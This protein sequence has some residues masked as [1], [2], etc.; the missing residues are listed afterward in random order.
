M[1]TLRRRT[2]CRPARLSAV[3]AALTCALLGSVVWGASTV[4]TNAPER[5]AEINVRDFGAVG[6]GVHDDTAA[7][8]KA[9]AW[10]MANRQELKHGVRRYRNV[11]RDCPTAPIRFPR[12]VYRITRPI[13]V[14]GDAILL[15]EEGARIVNAS[16]DKETFYFRRARY[17]RVTHLDFEGGLTQVRLWTGNRECSYLHVADCTFRNATGTSVECISRRDPPKTGKPTEMA[18]GETR[19]G[20]WHNSTLIIVERSRFLGNNMALRMFSDGVTVRDCTFVA[21]ANA[22]TPQL[23]MGS[24]G[25]QGVKI[26]LRD[27]SL[28]YPG[29]PTAEAAILFEGGRGMFE[30]IGISTPGNLAA[31]RSRTLMGEYKPSSLDVR[32]MALHTGNAPVFS[33]HSCEAP[34]RVSAYDLVSSTPDR[35]PMFVFD[36]EP[37]EELLGHIFMDTNRWSRIPLENALAFV[38]RNVDETRFDPALPFALRKFARA[39]APATWKRPLAHAS[40]ATFASNLPQGPVFAGAPLAELL[41]RARAAKGGTIVLDAAWHSADQTFS[42]PDNVRITCPGRA[43]IEARD[44]SYPIFVVE[45]GAR[46]AFENLMLVD[47]RHAIAATGAAGSVRIL[48]CTFF[49]QMEASIA[50]HGPVPGAV[51]IEVAG[52]QAFTPFLYRGNA[53]FTVDGFWLEETTDH[54]AGEYRPTF[55]TIVN[56]TGGR[57]L[58]RDFLGVPCYF[59]HHPK[60]EAYTFDCHPERRGE[61]RWVDNHGLYAAINVRHGGEWGGLTPA[62]HFGDA[63]TFIEGG[64]VDIRCFWIKGD[65]AVVVADRQ[66]ANVTLIDTNDG[67][68]LEPFQACV[69]RADGTYELLRSVRLANNFPPAGNVPVWPVRVADCSDDEVAFSCPF[70]WDG[71]PSVSLELEASGL[72]DVRLNGDLMGTGPLPSTSPRGSRMA[73]FRLS[74]KKG[75]NELSILARRGEGTGYLHARVMAGAHMIA[76]TAPDGDFVCGRPLEERIKPPRYRA[77]L[78]PRPRPQ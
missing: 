14:T 70:D 54:E 40:G 68:Y 8:G 2:K 66:G 31:I 48:D 59:H 21:P 28:S 53:E 26:Y 13:V 35:K 75:R 64:S 57:M 3:L 25:P 56:E 24:Q 52:G 47:G 38:W 39:A 19:G 62:Y 9:A 33:F 42:V 11:V 16:P 12:G 17:L 37:T 50:A 67:H 34:S 27:L 55:A 74:P 63:T 73:I 4:A 22:A 20:P 49:G 51:R 5:R 78:I 77:D 18:Y 36:Q 65:R 7:I 30:N 43:A 71:H 46:C 61:F 58:L 60:P 29:Q 44:G 76:R 10:L 6:D 1:S 32:G 23:D 45:D 15:G 69:K 41:A 72:C